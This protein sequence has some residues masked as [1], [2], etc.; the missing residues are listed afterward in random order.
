MTTARSFA[1]MRLASS[2]KSS[3]VTCL[4]IMTKFF[5][6]LATVGQCTDKQ[7]SVAR[8]REDGRAAATGAQKI[9]RRDVFQRHS[10]DSNTEMV[11]PRPNSSSVSPDKVGLVALAETAAWPSGMTS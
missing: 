5:P 8:T 11:Q 10:E 2:G 3:A 9:R 6:S 1:P 4:P 7:A